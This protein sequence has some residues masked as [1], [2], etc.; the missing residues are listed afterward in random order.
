MEIGLSLG[1][2]LGDRLGSLRE[3]AERIG[4][5]PGVRVVA[6]APVYETEPVDA[7]PEHAALKYLNSVLIIESSTDL[8]V[9]SEALHAIE[10]SLG[11]RR[12][13]D[14]NAPR[15]IDIDVIYADSARRR[16]GRLDLPHPRWAERRFVVQPLADV[17]PGL[18]VESGGMTVAERL[19]VLP[20]DGQIIRCVSTDWFK[21]CERKES[22]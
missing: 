13:A 5:L 20:A 4:A 1:S 21:P 22:L 16:D 2:N 11:R 14:R 19:K 12:V 3:A 9:L 18:V 7:S 8:D 17:R 6:A 10:D 15:T